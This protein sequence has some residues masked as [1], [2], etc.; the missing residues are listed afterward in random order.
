[1][2][3]V[4]LDHAATTPLD[5]RAAEAMQPYLH[6]TFGNTSSS[7]RAGRA[8]ERAVE[9]ARETCAQVLGCEPG[10]IVFTSGGTESD[11]L[12]VRGAAWARAHERRHLVTAATEHQAVGKTVEQMAAVMGFTRSLVP[13]DGYGRVTAD[14]LAATLTAQTGVVSLMTANN[15]VGTVQPVAALAEAAHRA[16]AVFHTDAVQ[17][18]GVLPLHMRALGLDLL[19]LSAHK[20]YGPKGVGLL[21][22][23]AGTPLLPMQS[24]GSHEEG[25]RA[26]TLNT[27]GIVGMATALKLAEEEREAR[28]AHYTARR[29][30]LIDAVCARIPGAALTGHPTERLPHHASFILDG[31]DGNTLLM[32]LDMKGVAASSGSACK[33]GSPEPS[34]VL[35]AMGY[36][37]EQALGSLRLTVGMSTTE[38][39]IAYAVNALEAAVAQVRRLH[40]VFA[41]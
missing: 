40:R 32:H 35:I 31:I 17:A 15:E 20:F 36:T 3:S 33:T 10:E 39:D 23:R 28:V 6:E 21:V 18:A 25:R 26:G 27:A 30:Q 22:V 34:G 12:A 13:V 37:P 2:R 24:G 9:Q 38:A 29:D 1:M 14:R 11:N 19:S 16:G 8:A 41:E 4:Y 7:H 5:P